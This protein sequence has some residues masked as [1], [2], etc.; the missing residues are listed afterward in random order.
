MRSA[1]LV[2]TVMGRRASSRA[3]GDGRRRA[4]AFTAVV[5]GVLLLL[6]GCGRAEQQS[7]GGGGGLSGTI[8]ADG[9]STVFPITE[10]MAEQFRKENSGVRLSVGVSGT[11]G[12]FKKF[13]AGETDMSN[14]SRP[15]KASEVEACRGAGVEFVELAVAYDGL[16]VVVNKNNSWISEITV[17]E[18]KRIW[19]PE[20]Q[21][22]VTRWVDV[23]PDLPGRPLTLYGAGTD[24]GTFDYFTE[25]IVGKED[26]SRGDYTASE[27]DNVLVQGVAGDENALGYFGY[28]YY[29][30]NRDK[31]KALAVVNPQTGRPVE[32]TE[33]SIRS[34]EYSPLS[35]PLFIYVSRKALDRPEVEA[36]VQFYLSHPEIVSQARYVPLSDALYQKMRDRA[37]ARTTGTTFQGT[38]QLPPGGLEAHYG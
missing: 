28:S 14:A 21:G 2:E 35:R 16:S 12:G 25:A 38:T 23:R 8:T 9:S 19:E 17:E 3:P 5:L 4:V 13:C 29:A 27:D 18:L 33:E 31:L 30:E 7:A 15:I 20:A 1:S 26:A 6:A 37:A 32:P 36:F 22:K 24:S 34:G 11:G 10:A